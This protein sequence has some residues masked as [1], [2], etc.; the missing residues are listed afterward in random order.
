MTIVF[1]FPSKTIFRFFFYF[2]FP[3]S[4]FYVLLATA[5]V[6]GVPAPFS[7]PLAHA[8]TRKKHGGVCVTATT[9]L[10]PTLQPSDDSPSPLPVEAEDAAQEMRESEATRAS[11]GEQVKKKWHPRAARSLS[12]RN[13]AGQ[14]CP[15][16]AAP[17]GRRAC[18][19]VPEDA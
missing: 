16:R 11:D 9:L 13:C 12:S 14:V 10:L 5:G 4:F 3:L 18:R 2:S 7:L 8:H 19:H 15:A 1:L 17:G 6:G